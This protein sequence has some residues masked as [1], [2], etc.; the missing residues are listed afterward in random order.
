MTT[1]PAGL[2]RRYAAWSLDFAVLSL[3]ALLVTWSR[4][5]T[6]AT[7]LSASFH[8]L[9]NTMAEHVG[10][11]VTHGGDP[12]ALATQLLADP[13]VR[14]GS[15]AVQ[16]A[17][18]ALVLPPLLAY[19]LLGLLYHVGGEA[20]AWRGSPGKRALGLEVARADGTRPAL[21]QLVVRH[22]AGALS[23]LT[24]N[25]GHAL[26]LVPPHRALHDMLSG[27]AVLQHSGDARLPGWAR[28]WL[29]LQVL[30]VTVVSLWGLLRY[31]ALMQAALG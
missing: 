24:L 7:A 16:S 30:A 6:A 14:A 3:A 18:S 5:R 12:V 10:A 11:L 31:L 19:A 27:T 29:A 2:V 9:S 28:A 21:W 4:M 26:A 1:P 8:A 23:W 15:E 25:L 13:G 20:S 17:L 22:I